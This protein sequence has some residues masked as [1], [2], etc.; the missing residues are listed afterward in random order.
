M[1]ASMCVITCDACVYTCFSYPVEKEIKYYSP[2]V[3]VFWKTYMVEYKVTENLI[4]LNIS[5]YY[6]YVLTNRRIIWLS[7][8]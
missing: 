5:F 4:L 3:T 8:W 7:T 1:H 6:V 2:Y